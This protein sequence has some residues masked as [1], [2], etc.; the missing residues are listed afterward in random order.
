MAPCFLENR[1]VEFK[2]TLVTQ[3][4]MIVSGCAVSL[5]EVHQRMPKHRN[6]KVHF[7]LVTTDRQCPFARLVQ[8]W[9]CQHYL[10]QPALG[11]CKET[12]QGLTRRLRESGPMFWCDSKTRYDSY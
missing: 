7:G 1:T 10:V 12:L 4:K 9:H 11:T 8:Q 5:D 3:T 2:L 6:D